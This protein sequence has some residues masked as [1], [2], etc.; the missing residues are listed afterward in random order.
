MSTDY[1]GISSK[2]GD[3]LNFSLDFDSQTGC[4]AAL[5]IASIPEGW[6]GYFKGGSSEVSKVHVNYGDNDGLAT[7]NVSSPRE[8]ESGVYQIQLKADAGEGMEDVLTLEIDVTEVEAGQ[9]NFSSEYPEQEG[10]AGTSFTFDTTLVNNKANEQSYS[11]SA[12]APTGWQVSFVPSGESTNVASIS[13]D[14]GG[15]QGMSVKITPP[16]TITEGEY[17]IPCTAVS[18]TETL[19]LDLKVNITGSYDVSL[20]TPDGKVSFDAYANDEKTVTLKITNNGNVDLENLNLTSSLPSDWEI[21]FDESTI[22]LLEA[23]AEKEINAYITPASDS[24]TG[25][26]VASISIA[27]DLTKSSVEFRVSVK[28]RTSW[29]VLAIAIIAAMAAGLGYIFKKYGRR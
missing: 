2:A 19:S 3:S 9:S 1:P 26:Y 16:E 25:D 10:S 14:A 22:E 28:T 23:G 5:S 24:M 27:N 12:N 15:S 4:D 21:R 7:F 11:L 29:G 8:T 17:E 6:E 20:S 18:A 13:V